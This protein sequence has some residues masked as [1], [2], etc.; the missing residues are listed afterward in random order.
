M[1]RSFLLLLVAGVIVSFFLSGCAG[2]G[3]LHPYRREKG[4]LV[5]VEDPQGLVSDRHALTL[6]LAD[7][8]NAQLNGGQ[9]LF[10]KALQKKLL[11]FQGAQVSEVCRSLSCYARAAQSWNKKFLL[12][13]RIKRDED[14]SNPR[15]FL[16]LSRWSVSPLFP[17]MTVQVSFSLDRVGSEGLEPVF[18]QAVKLMMLRLKPHQNH[19]N[20]S[21]PTNE[22]AAL[23]ARGKTDLAM[24]KGEEAFLSGA[25]QPP[26]FYS[27]L[28]RLEMNAG[29]PKMAHEVGERALTLK[30]ASPPLLIDMIRDARDAGDSGMERN[31]LF[32]GVSLYPNDEV[33]WT[34][35][36]HQDLREGRYEKALATIRLY[37]HRNPPRTGHPSFPQEK[38]AALVGLGRGDEA[39]QWLK[40][41]ISKNWMEA[42][43]PSLLLAHAVIT[44][45]LQKGQWRKAEKLARILAARG[46]RSK[47]LYRDWMTALGAMGNSIMEAHVGRQAIAAGY[48]SGWI[49]R[50]VAFLAQ[51]G[52]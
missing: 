10:G 27:S 9:V 25:P 4:V 16:V 2:G 30:K 28:Y 52:Y 12:E 44:R 26:S 7:V 13:A 49:D 1:G 32:Q 21:D 18:D 17:E 45:E 29:K 11:K 51:K 14:V 42:P 47:E 20:P 31:L 5:P 6:Y 36:I 50:Q 41:A 22:I 8:Y 38:Y 46:I 39:D 34:G 48:T 19:G 15:G 3:H 40:K 37:D 43:H 33:F 24:R 35:L 23:L